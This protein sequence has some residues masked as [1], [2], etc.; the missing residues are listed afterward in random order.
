MQSERLK[1]FCFLLLGL[2]LAFLSIRKSHRPDLFFYYLDVIDFANRYAAIPGLVNLNPSMAYNN[3]FHLFT[4]LIDSGPW[5]HRSVYIPLGVMYWAAMGHFMSSAC[6]I[7]KNEI[8]VESL[9]SFF[10]LP[11]LSYSVITGTVSSA[12]TNE[13]TWILTALVVKYLLAMESEKKKGDTD[14]F[15][16]LPKESLHL[17]ILAFF[18]S[19]TALINKLSALPILASMMIAVPVYCRGLFRDKQV[20]HLLMASIAFSAT[21]LAIHISRNAILSGWVWYPSPVGNFGFDWSF[22]A[23]SML[24]GIRAKQAE[25]RMMGSWW[26][27]NPSDSFLVWLC[28]ILKSML[29]E[30]GFLLLLYSLPVFVL[31]LL[32]RCFIQREKYAFPWWISVLVCA[33]GVLF[34]GS[35]NPYIDYAYGY[36]WCFAALSLASLFTIFSSRNIFRPLLIVTAV[37]LASWYYQYTFPWHVKNFSSTVNY[38]LLLTVPPHGKGTSSIDFSRG[39]W[40]VEE[41]PISYTFPIPQKGN[42][43]FPREKTFLE[44]RKPGDISRGFRLSFDDGR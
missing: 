18:I 43:W 42:P 9:F 5:E 37:M 21:V 41:L 3:T 36:I 10:M 27:Y 31:S 15:S 16:P 39:R 20:R 29:R 30:K 25:A 38:Q 8:S 22:P 19:I 33:G 14:F 26:A 28:P 1:S 40:R 6:K 2:V 44:M 32:L 35:Q 34:V 23:D 11:F 12:G 24:S 17:L 7:L 4:A 13:L